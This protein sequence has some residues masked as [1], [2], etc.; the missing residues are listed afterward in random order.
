MNL[1]LKLLLLAGESVGRCGRRCTAV[2]E[3]YFSPPMHY[4]YRIL[5]AEAFQEPKCTS[6]VYIYALEP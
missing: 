4:R 5:R 2:A 1:R 6:S 3:C